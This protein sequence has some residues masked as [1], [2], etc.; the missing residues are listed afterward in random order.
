MNNNNSCIYWD[1]L[2]WWNTK[3][4]FIFQSLFLCFYLPISWLCLISMFDLQLIY[5]WNINL[6][7][8]KIYFLNFNRKIC[9]SLI[10][11][12]LSRVSYW[13]LQIHSIKGGWLL[14]SNKIR[15]VWCWWQLMLMTIL[16]VF[17]FPSISYVY[18]WLKINTKKITP[19]KRGGLCVGVIV[20]ASPCSTYF[21]SPIITYFCIASVLIAHTV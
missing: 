14:S 16:F 13:R 20:Y 18:R 2:Q 4:S 7:S 3:P 1:L 6:Y 15:R 19:W 5:A 21:K 12:A 8:L 11:L 9:F 17:F 10:C